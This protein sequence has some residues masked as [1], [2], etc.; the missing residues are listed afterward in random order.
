MSEARI[1]IGGDIVPTTS[2]IHCFEDGHLEDI[3]SCELMEFI[4]G[5]DA[6]LFNLETPL[7]DIHAPIKKEGPCFRA[8]EKSVN[9]LK[10][11]NPSVVTLANNHIL[12]QDVQGLRSTTNALSS[13]NISYVG[14]GENLHE[15]NKAVFFEVHD[16]KIAV[17]GCVEHE[18]T[19]ATEYR[20]GANPFDALEIADTIRNIKKNA[21]YVIVLYHGGREYYE[22]PSPELMRRCRKMASCGADVILCQHSH[23]IG[24]YEEYEGSK[25]LYGQGNFILDRYVKAFENHF[26]TSLLVELL[27]DETGISWKLHPLHKEANGVRFADENERKEIQ[28]GIEKRSL[29]IRNHNFVKENYKRYAEIYASRFI[30]RFNRFG[31]I[32]SSLDNRFFGGKILN[33]SLKKYMGKH[34]RLAIQNCIQCEVYN[35]LL[36]T[37]LS[38]EK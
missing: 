10:Q 30:F 9:G 7:A 31:Y 5:A 26:Q 37:Y 6:R 16:I 8:S 25:I 33:R 34:Q 3:V 11:L 14:V 38:D 4:L 21:D 32:I 29:Q 35:E 15:A 17:Y 24:A 12:D 20:P 13:K 23:C 1:V 28:N 36:C 27:V 22:Y 19:F 2:N 18:Y